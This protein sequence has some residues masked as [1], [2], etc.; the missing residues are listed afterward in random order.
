MDA[1]MTPKV[2]VLMPAYNAEKYLRESVLSI[3]KQTFTDFEL[4]IINDGSTDQ[5]LSVA[6]SF[7]DPRI[8]IIDNKQNSG[9]VA[10]R[11]QAIKAAQGKYIAWLDSDDIALPKRL[12]KQ[13]VF[14]DRHPDQGLLGTAVALIDESGKRTGVRW[15]NKT[16]AEE[17]LVVMLFHNCFTQSSV[18]IRKSAIPQDGY[19]EGFAPAED[20]DLWIRIAENWK[21]SNLPEILTEYRKYAGSVSGSNT[22]KGQVSIEKVVRNELEKFGINPTEEEYR[23]HRTSYGYSGTDM[24]EFLKRRESWLT[25]LISVNAERK[26]IDPVLFEK[27]ISD[28]W[29]ISCA[30]NA[31]RGLSVWKYCWHSPLAKHIGWKKNWDEIWI[32][33]VKMLLKKDSLR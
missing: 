26:K 22:P 4:I 27:I 5:T 15:K 32:F 14:M 1:D 30:S 6:K 33:M 2:S 9:L 18:M 20:Y 19:R 3:L 28:R 16:P 23:I 12:E 8:K 25:H 29:L 11:N 13:V 7:T 24:L 10:V 31:R 17:M 21:C